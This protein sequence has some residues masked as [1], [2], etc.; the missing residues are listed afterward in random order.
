MVRAASVGELSRSA[1][2]KCAHTMRSDFLTADRILETADLRIRARSAARW[3]SSGELWSTWRPDASPV[4][5]RTARLVRGVLDCDRCGA[6]GAR[7]PASIFCRAENRSRIEEF[8]TKHDLDRHRA[9]SHST[10]AGRRSFLRPSGGAMLISP[11][12]STGPRRRSSRSRPSPTTGRRS[13]ASPTCA[14]TTTACCA[15]DDPRGG[16]RPLPPGRL[17]QPRPTSLPGPSS[18]AVSSTRAGPST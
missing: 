16:A 9:M 12:R 11:G 2:R 17:R 10:S 13:S 15:P 8:C 5:Q 14:R 3:S 6:S 1:R 18:R 4:R 7:R